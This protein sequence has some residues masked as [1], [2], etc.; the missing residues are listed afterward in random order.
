[1]T[2]VLNV[3]QNVPSAQDQQLAV[4]SVPLV[5]GTIQTSA[6]SV[7]VLAMDALP[8]PISASTVQTAISMPATPT[9]HAASLVSQ[10]NLA[11]G[12]PLPVRPVLC[13]VQHVR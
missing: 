1:M 6:P 7:M 5:T 13:S 8:Q 9:E 10:I 4:Q 2:P 3:I 11:T 12:I